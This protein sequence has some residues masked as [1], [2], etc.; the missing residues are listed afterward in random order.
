MSSKL[1]TG[2]ALRAGK[3]ALFIL[4]ASFAAVAY[5]I[6]SEV[7]ELALIDDLEQLDA[8]G[9]EYYDEETSA[10]VDANDE[11]QRHAMFGY[12]AAVVL[13]TIVLL[14]WTSRTNRAC[15]DLGA[16]G[17]EF[18]PGW[19][20]GFWLIPILNLVKPFQIV[21]ELW[22]TTDPDGRASPLVGCWWIAWLGSGFVARFAARDLPADATLEDFRHADHANLLSHGVD[23]IAFALTI[24]VV[25]KLTARLKAYH[26]RVEPAAARVVHEDVA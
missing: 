17:M 20:W 18:T 21:R 26:D 1:S 7:Q 3:V 13:S 14:I 15:R 23:I 16:R 10:R 25:T 8:A 5:N 22:T 4:W 2:R 6:Y 19:A 9:V 24:V 12:L 11:R